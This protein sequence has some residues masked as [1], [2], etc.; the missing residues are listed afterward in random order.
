M[1]LKF[2][3]NGLICAIAQDYE[4]GEVLMQA[5]MNREAF[6]KTLETGYAHYWSRS[7]QKL[8]KKG[9]ESGHLQ[10][11]IGVYLDCD[12]D[13]VLLKVQQTGAACHTGNYTCFFTPV[14]ECGVGA[15]MLGQLQRIVEDRKENPEEGS[16]TNYLFDKGVDKIAKKA[17]EEAVELVIAAKNGDKEEIVGECAD[18]FYHTLVLLANAGVKLSDVCTELKNRH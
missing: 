6:D 14:R 8:W 1:Q 15:E 3:G 7:R 2:D 17:G 4:S 18:L 11:V 9:E 12:S 5:Y 10:K 16:Y 13:C